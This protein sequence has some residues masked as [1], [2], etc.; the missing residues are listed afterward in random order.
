MNV[1]PIK[2][3]RNGP[4]KFLTSCSPQEVEVRYA[5]GRFEDWLRARNVGTSVSENAK[6]ALAEALNNVVEHSGADK[7]T[8]VFVDASYLEETLEIN[9][10]DSGDPL[11]DWLVRL[12]CSDEPMSVDGER[13]PMAEPGLSEGEL[14]EGGFGWGLIHA[15]TAFRT[16]K[17][18][19]T[20]NQLTLVIGH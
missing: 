19:E 6:I 20:E 9:V 4:E 1:D 7:E 15:L 14:P 2:V 12:H 10:C 17:R 16:Y 11:P 13:N 18:N 8:K 3:Q 5:L